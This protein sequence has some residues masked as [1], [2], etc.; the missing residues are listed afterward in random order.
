MTTVPKRILVV[1]DRITSY[2]VCYTK[3]LRLELYK[4]VQKE[5]RALVIRNG[6]PEEDRSDEILKR[7]LRL[8]QIASNPHLVA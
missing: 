3:L 6:I 5:E 7:L 4:Q 2:N 1:D 8:L